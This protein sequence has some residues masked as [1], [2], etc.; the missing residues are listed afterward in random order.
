VQLRY[1]A[2][3]G[4]AILAGST[5]AAA[6]LTVDSDPLAAFP[7]SPA[8]RALREAEGSSGNHL[9]V[10]SVPAGHESSEY[11][12]LVEEIAA[13]HEAL[14]M[15]GSVEYRLPDPGDLIQSLLP[16]FT[17][18]LTPAELDEVA[19]R[20]TTAAIERAVARNRSILQSP[21][22]VAARELVQFDPF[23][24]L[25]IFLRKFGGGPQSMQLDPASGYLLSK[26]GSTMLIA[27][28]PKEPPSD[29]LF[30]RDFLARSEAI[31]TRS[32]QAFASSAGGSPPPVVAF[33]GPYARAVARDDRALRDVAVTSLLGFFF[34][35]AVGAAAW[36]QFAAVARFALA[37]SIAAVATFALAALLRDA[38]PVMAFYALPPALGAGA[39]TL[40]V[41]AEKGR[42]TLGLAVAAAFL[43]L[44]AS[45]FPALRG[46]GLLGA[47]CVLLVI[48]AG[49]LIGPLPV[50]RAFNIA[51]LS[52][53][54][55][56][57]H[58][59]TVTV[60]II[61]LILLI[62]PMVW[63]GWDGTLRDYEVPVSA[64]D[65]AEELAETKFG[66]LNAPTTIVLRGPSLGELQER[67]AAV[68]SELDAL[69][70]SGRIRAYQ[71]G[72]KFLP[73]RSAQLKSIA[74][75]VAGGKDRFSAE[76]IRADFYRSLTA[77]G[78]R[79]EAYD[80]YMSGFS[81]ALNARAPIAIENLNDPVLSSLLRAFVRRSGRGYVSSI[82]VQGSPQEVGPVAGRHRGVL[83]GERAVA[84]SLHTTA[85]GRLPLILVLAA[86][87]A[88]VLAG[89]AL[90]SV[91]GTLLAALAGAAAITAWLAVAVTGGTNSLTLT[92]SALA[93]AAGT[94]L[95]AHAVRGSSVFMPGLL[96]IAGAGAL[97]LAAIPAGRE[98]A[99][100]AGAGFAAGALAA[101]TLVPALTRKYRQ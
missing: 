74:V 35:L 51:A 99:L 25:P 50:P 88:L 15:V 91:R 70:R 76:R 58:R 22:S 30:S 44:T 33:A 16:R 27:V 94:A 42:A 24:L 71:S 31:R 46:F 69:V 36:R 72:S 63:T 81:E 96:M 1:R 8:V 66:A 21:Q 73:P 28:R 77:N 26:D 89:D 2:L 39:A 64:I 45:S 47:A 93:L 84:H 34:T 100:C 95:G 83:T 52:Q 68:S 17:L 9:I 61:A 29:L 14:P 18:L 13:A 65:R 38:I 23:N 79:P 43:A 3:I 62:V 90:R 59:R 56:A 20:L 87:A 6:S 41:R 12:A 7:P 54:A 48:A 55:V 78:F 53:R 75:L 4:A 67:T 86:L 97:A 5:F 40:F 32:L 57:A 92:A 85:M 60:W 80:E 10:V 82:E 49:A 37:L 19:G 11:E 101:L 98:L